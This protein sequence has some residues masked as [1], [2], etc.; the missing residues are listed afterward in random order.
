MSKGHILLEKK[1]STLPNTLQTHES[2]KYKMFPE[3]F[4]FIGKKNISEGFQ[5]ISVFFMK[6]LKFLIQLFEKLL[7]FEFH[8]I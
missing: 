8:D 6:F 2:C 1:L 7:S 3:S 4:K 5:I